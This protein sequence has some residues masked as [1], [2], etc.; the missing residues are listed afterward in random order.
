MSSNIYFS[1]KKQR[2]LSWWIVRA[3]T[4][5]IL[6]LPQ[7]TNVKIAKK[8][9]LKPDRR[10]MVTLPQSMSQQTLNTVSGNV[11]V[12][13]IGKGPVILLSH[14]WSGSASQLFALMIKIAEAGFQAVSF[15]HLGH[16]Q[17][18]GDEANLFL[19]IKTKKL[20]IELI[21]KEQPLKTIISHSMG[22]AA[23]LNAFN[24]P[25]PLLLIA[26]VFKFS[27]A[28]FE[29]VEQS[30]VARQLLENVLADLERQHGMDFIASDPIHHVDNYS[31]DIH[32]VHDIDDQFSPIIDSV[33]IAEANAHVKLTMTNNLGHGKV[34]ASD[35]T[36]V[37]FLKMMGIYTSFTTNLLKH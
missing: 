3:I 16:G 30:G 36:W 34:I 9:L 24:G 18:D 15:D 17:S 35:D 25:Q 1:D 8:L 6:L 23:A 21:E 5:L 29:K 33:Q 27:E 13:K 2:K 32:I 37:E 10:K 22:S 26:P 4:N 20:I 19:F 14:G 11:A 7:A 31:G 28:M 12:Y